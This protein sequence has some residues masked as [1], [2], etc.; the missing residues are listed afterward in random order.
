V[1]GNDPM[2][3][4][5]SLGSRPGKKCLWWKKPS[6]ESTEEKVSGRMVHTTG[7]GR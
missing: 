1:K 5:S 3:P 6:A 2:C 7:R 4:G